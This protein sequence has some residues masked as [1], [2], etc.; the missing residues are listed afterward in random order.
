MACFIFVVMVTPALLFIIIIIIIHILHQYT[1]TGRHALTQ[2]HTH[3]RTYL[4]SLC[5]YKCNQHMRKRKIS[6]HP[7]EFFHC[8]A[9]PLLFSHSLLLQFRFLVGKWNHLYATSKLLSCIYRIRRDLVSV[10]FFYPFR[11]HSFGA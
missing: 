1:H 7:T 6:I 2:I 11:C 8:Y 10:N 4:H 9:L 5:F 3:T